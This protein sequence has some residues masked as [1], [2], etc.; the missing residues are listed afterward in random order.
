M[1]LNVVEAVAS[2]LLPVSVCSEHRNDMLLHEQATK[3]RDLVIMIASAL[4]ISPNGPDAFV[5]INCLRYFIHNRRNPKVHISDLF[6]TP[7]EKQ[8]LRA[9]W[10]RFEQDVLDLNE[11]ARNLM[12]LARSRGRA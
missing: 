12:A 1:L 11:G 9:T 4:E 3:F 2:G 6:D 5:S 8:L 7:R 10:A